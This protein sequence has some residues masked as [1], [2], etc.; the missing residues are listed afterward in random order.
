MKEQFHYTRKNGFRVIIS[1]IVLKELVHD[2]KLYYFQSVE[3]TPLISSYGYIQE[4]P[5]MLRINPALTVQK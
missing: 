2:S 3:Y 5:T 1:I 4:T